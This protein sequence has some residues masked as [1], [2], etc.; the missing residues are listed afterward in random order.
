[1]SN[2]PIVRLLGLA[3]KAGRLEIGEE[4]VGG[5]CR[6]RQA[7]LIL[8]ASDAADN[9][10]HRA[11]NFSAAGKTS[12]I[13]IPYGKEVLGHACGQHVCAMAAI[14]DVSLARA[15]VLALDQPEQY[16]ALLSDLDRRVRRVRQ[17]RQEERAHRN[18]VKHGRK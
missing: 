14:T 10:L 18:N 7:R 3:K 1:M 2:D 12:W 6:A 13:R 8:V 11:R 4:P 15:F 17:R 16:E 5:A 9:A